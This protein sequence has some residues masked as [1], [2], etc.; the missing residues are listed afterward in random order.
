MSI[1]P[2]TYGN[3]E[4]KRFQKLYGI[5]S[6]NLLLCNPP[7]PPNVSP[8]IIK[9]LGLHKFVNLVLPSCGDQDM[10][11]IIE[12]IAFHK[13]DGISYVCQDAINIKDVFAK[14]LELPS[15]V[16]SDAL[17]DLNCENVKVAAR[18]LIT[19]YV[20]SNH[21]MS[22]ALP[23]SVHDAYDLIR[24]GLAHK[25][26]WARLILEAAM[27]EINCMTNKTLDIPQ[28][29]CSYSAY[30]HKILEVEGF[31]AKKNRR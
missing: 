27:K 29:R 12:L 22:R 31:L 28:L 4:Q 30:W 13:E 23:D 18:K 1:R 5:I 8:A 10:N 2:V 6:R 9:A 25:I 7:A 17:L 26:D 16:P 20:L 3:E 14:D 21:G 19:A 24:K 15:G 11:R